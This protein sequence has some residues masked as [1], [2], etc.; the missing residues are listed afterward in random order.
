LKN[1]FG[2]QLTLL[3]RRFSDAGIAPAL[4]YLLLIAVFISC[5]LFLF[6]KTEYA[7][8]LYVLMAVALTSPLAEKRR[9]EFLKICY[10]DM[11]LKQ[12]RVMENLVIALPFIIFLLYKQYY[13]FALALLLLTSLLA[14]VSSRTSFS[15]IIPTPFHKKPFEF[16]VGFRNTYYILVAA[17]GLTAIGIAV[18]NFNLGIVAMLFVVGVTMTYYTK[19]EHP[20]YVWIHNQNAK[21]FLIAK[22][23]TALQYTAWLILPLMIALMI[24]FPENAW[25]VLGFGALSLLYLICMIVSKY[26]AYPDELNVPQALLLGMCIWLPP[27][28][29]ILIPYFSHKAIRDLSPRLP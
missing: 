28:L 17:Y 14:L 12:I 9:N 1:Y 23:K 24:K 18:G 3:N 13:L 29:L 20:Y 2:L 26:A 19:P 5:S 25:I 6:Y 15:I 16:I 7:P 22:I 27:L 21:Q 10:G 4:A 8:Y 11:R